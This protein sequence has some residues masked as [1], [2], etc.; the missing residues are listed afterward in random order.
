MA[1]TVVQPSKVGKVD[2]LE[3]KPHD[4]QKSMKMVGINSSY[5]LSDGFCP[6]TT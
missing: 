2:L 5:C 1:E 6:V 4:S 3:N